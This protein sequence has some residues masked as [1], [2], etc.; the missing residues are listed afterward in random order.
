MIYA[1]ITYVTQPNLMFFTYIWLV[2]IVNYGKLAD[3]QLVPPRM[4]EVEVGL[5]TVIKSKSF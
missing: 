3:F 1:N 2:I 4:L 5:Y